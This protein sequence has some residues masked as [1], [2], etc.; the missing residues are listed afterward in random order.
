RAAVRLADPPLRALGGVSEGGA[1]GGRASLREGRLQ[2][3]RSGEDH[4]SLA[5]PAE[6]R[7]PMIGSLL[8]L[9]LAAKPYGIQDLEALFESRAYLELAE[10]LGDVP[11]AK[12]DAAWTKLAE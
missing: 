5:S 11:P 9:T 7:R 12:R 6:R 1:E 3:G 2:Q 8:I 4:R 10:H